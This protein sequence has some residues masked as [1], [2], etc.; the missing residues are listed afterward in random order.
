MTFDADIKKS[1]N[2][3]SMNYHKKQQIL[4]QSSPLM[5]VVHGYGEHIERYQ[6]L[7]DYF[8]QSGISVL[9][10]DLRGHGRSDG[11]RAMIQTFQDY[12]EDLDYHMQTLPAH[13]NLYLYGHS[14]GALIVANWLIENSYSQIKKCILSSGLFK[15]DDSV[16]PILRKIAPIA[17]FLLPS[18][19]TSKIEVNKISSLPEEVLR[20]QSDPYIYHGG[21]KAR[22]GYELMKAMQKINNQWHNIKIPTLFLQ[23]ESDT[24]TH[25]QGS[26]LGYNK[27][28]AKHKEL[29]LFTDAK[30]ELLNDYCQEEYLSTIRNFLKE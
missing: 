11:R 20:Y 27:I 9:G 21:T 23:G 26:I 29:K 3:K 28:A 30:H 15:L 4:P 16:S 1:T 6:K 24:L 17:S 18:L 5:I 14:M 19:S 10:F 13:E 2:S 25:P 8:N 22:T 12:I 7:F